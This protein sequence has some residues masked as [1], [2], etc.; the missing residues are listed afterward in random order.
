VISSSQRPHHEGALVPTPHHTQS[1]AGHQAMV[2]ALVGVRIQRQ[3]NGHSGAAITGPPS[4]LFVYLAP[5]RGMRAR[6]VPWTTRSACFAGYCP[7]TS[8]IATEAR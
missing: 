6:T 1:R 4:K 2:R 3:F 5:S 8:V 7:R